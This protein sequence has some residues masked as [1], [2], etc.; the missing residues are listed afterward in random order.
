MISVDSAKILIQEYAAKTN[1]AYISLVEANGYILA[2]NIYA[3]ID[4]PPFNT[5]AMDGY[6]IKLDQ[7]YYQKTWVVKGEIQAGSLI[8]EELQSNE[9]Y[10]IFTGAMVPLTADT[11]VVQEKVIRN[12]DEFT[13]EEHILVRG[14][15][16]RPQ[17][18][19]LKK[20][21]LVLPQGHKLNAAA[22]SL[23]ANIGFN[24][25]KVYE[26]PQIGIVVTGK[27]LV[28][29]GDSLPAGMIYESNSYALIAALNEL[30]ITPSSVSRVDDIREE[31]VEAI[32]K[33][34]DKNILILTGGVSV[35][36]YDFVADSLLECGVKK[37]FHKVK[38]KPGKPFYF[39]VKDETLIFGLPG[40]PAAVLTCFYEYIVL[41]IEAYTGQNYYK[42]LTLPLTNSYT[43]KTSLTHFLKGKLNE[44][45][46]EI[47]KSQ[48]SYLLNSFAYADCIIELAETEEQFN[49]GD[50][51]RVKMIVK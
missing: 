26:K 47:L 6:A 18:S 28:Q 17:G 20:G 36:D 50:M 16:I 29:P 7:N 39:G 42:T 45:G 2:E 44:Q 11:I 25:V 43:K 40:N 13:I 15:N 51:V 1:E 10:R 22:I 32:E 31:I 49:I 19:Q 33:N 41:A 12:G 34:L 37:I 35:G 23:L 48:E 4:T 24:Q 21:E 5:S 27:E 8:E 46:V 9:A 38:Q 30:N 14:A 3:P